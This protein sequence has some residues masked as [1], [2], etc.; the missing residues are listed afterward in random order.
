MSECFVYSDS[1][2]VNDFVVGEKRGVTTEEM[3]REENVREKSTT[4]GKNELFNIRDEYRGNTVEEN[5]RLTRLFSHD[6]EI[7]ALNPACWH[8]IGTMIRTAFLFGFS[9][10]IILGRSQYDKRTAVGA[11]HYMDIVKYNIMEG[12]NNEFFS[13]EK[14]IAYLKNLENDYHFIF[15]EQ[16]EESTPLHIFPKMLIKGDKKKLFI[17]GA[18]SHG[19]PTQVLEHFK[20]MHSI[21]EI[22]QHGIGR[23]HNIVV[24]MSIVLWDFYWKSFF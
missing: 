3:T 14:I 9:K 17:F 2:D 24:S 13:A 1:E 11:H 23:S 6:D 19:I 10:F 7:L 4:E 18:E 22:P 5:K 20:N 8:N 15:V 16:H 21:V 12:D